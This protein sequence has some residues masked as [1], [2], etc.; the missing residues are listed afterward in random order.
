MAEARRQ[1]ADDR[2][3]KQRAED[4]RTEDRAQ[5]ICPASPFLVTTESLQY[6]VCPFFR[7]GRERPSLLSVAVIECRLRQRGEDM[8]ISYDRLGF[9]IKGSRGRG[10]SFLTHLPGSSAR[11]SS[12]HSEL[13]LSHQPAIKKMPYGCTHRPT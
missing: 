11:T 2:R 1:R 12:T 7:G 4:K 6:H 13:G 3:Q 8:V 5:H 9:I 10:H